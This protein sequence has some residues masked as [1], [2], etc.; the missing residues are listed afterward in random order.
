LRP[1]SAPEPRRDPAES[2]LNRAREIRA[3]EASVDF[4]KGR[5]GWARLLTAPGYGAGI[6]LIVWGVAAGALLP[7]LL[8][9][10]IVAIPVLTTDG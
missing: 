10:V 5:R 6:A 2:D 3:G 7:T 4:G 1:A 9:L 8:G